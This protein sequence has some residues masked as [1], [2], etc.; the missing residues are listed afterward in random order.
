MASSRTMTND[1]LHKKDSLLFYI[2]PLI[3][4]HVSCF[5]KTKGHADLN[6]FL[7]K[8]LKLQS[9]LVGDYHTFISSEWNFFL[10]HYS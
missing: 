7:F 10:K 3:F 9:I 2:G 1:P 8:W 4:E 6:A 5:V